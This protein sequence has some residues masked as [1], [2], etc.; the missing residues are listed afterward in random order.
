MKAAITEWQ[1]R[2]APVFDV[3]GTVL[4]YGPDG[5]EESYSLPMDCPQSKLSFLKERQVDVLIC[6]A[7][8]RR[9]R[10]Y[11]EELGIRVNPFVSGEVGE[12]WEAWKS[13]T[14]D[15]ACYSM[16]GCRRCRRRNGSC[17]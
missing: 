16:P 2:I 4:I 11:A 13:G 17:S 3:S 15:N 9:V 7:I 10:E 8:S 1:G 14:L 5:L 6:G 12:V